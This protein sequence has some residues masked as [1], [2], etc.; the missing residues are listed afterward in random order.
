MFPAINR[1][2]CLNHTIL[3][4]DP[5]VY[6][7]AITYLELPE[8][9]EVSLEDGLH[10]V[11]SRANRLRQLQGSGHSELSD[12]VIHDCFTGGSVPLELFTVE[13]WRDLAL[14]IK[15]DGILVVVS[16]KTSRISGLS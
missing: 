14:S 1:I 9:H 13:F 15:P 16:H 4:L 3:E 8:P 5:A 6:H 10:F 12:L 7:A 11:T 2:H